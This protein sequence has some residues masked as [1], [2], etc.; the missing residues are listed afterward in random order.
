MGQLAALGPMLAAAA[1]YI[2]AAGA[3]MSFIS[4]MQQAS[5]MEDQ[6]KAQQEIYNLQAKNAQ[7]VAERNAMIR[8]DE[9]KYSSA[10]DREQAI[11][12]EAVGLK[13]AK[14]TRRQTDLQISKGRAAAGASGGGVT[15]PTVLDMI[16]DVFETGEL[17]ARNELFE[18]QSRAS[19]LRSEAGLTDYMGERDSE[20]IRYGG[21][22][23]SNL[24]TAQ[25]GLA[26]YEGKASASAKRG[27]AVGTLFDG[28][29]SIA[30]KYKPKDLNAG[31]IPGQS[32]RWYASNDE[33]IDWN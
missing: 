21:A 17:N 4:S 27:E 23:D 3:G 30:T 32:S 29:S 18:G 2:S 10:R 12:E 1:P 20:M 8:A 11:Q 7:T 31:Y 28:M 26:R 22:T 16:D 6:G 25:G 14:E 5:A 9:A 19:L 33:W 15:D 13:R 24:L